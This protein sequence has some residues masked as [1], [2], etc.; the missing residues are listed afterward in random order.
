MG[1]CYAT[2]Y[3]VMWRTG[4]AAHAQSVNVICAHVQG[5]NAV[6][7]LIPPLTQLGFGRYMICGEYHRI[8]STHHWVT[9]LFTYLSVRPRLHQ[10]HTNTGQQ[11]NSVRWCLIYRV[12]QKKCIHSSLINIFGINL[13]EISISGWECNIIYNSRTSLISILLLHKYSSYD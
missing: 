6:V 9:N 12:A 13:N 11:V 8:A 5:A 1:Y 7:C 4:R 2:V 10:G 3:F